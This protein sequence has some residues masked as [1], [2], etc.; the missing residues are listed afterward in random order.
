M[1]YAWYVKVAPGKPQ[2]DRVKLEIS[3][4]TGEA[5]F[6]LGEEKKSSWSGF[7]GSVT[8]GGKMCPLKL[9]LLIM[10]QTIFGSRLVSDSSKIGTVEKTFAYLSIEF[11]ILVTTH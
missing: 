2:T 8:E 4:G 10:P 3:A 7:S 11:R 5:K 9:F 1:I 6:L